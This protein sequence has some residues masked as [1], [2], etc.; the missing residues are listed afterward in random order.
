MTTEELD[1]LS[2]NVP[3][4]TRHG[5]WFMYDGGAARVAREVRVKYF[6]VSQ[7]AYRYMDRNRQGCVLRD[8]PI[9]LLLTQTTRPSEAFRLFEE[10]ELRRLIKAAAIV[11]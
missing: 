6:L 7:Y 2:E 4:A 10:S 8:C 1:R 11:I 3:F 9:S 5:M